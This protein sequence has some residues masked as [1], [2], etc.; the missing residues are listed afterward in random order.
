MVD[1]N[2]GDGRENLAEVPFPAAARDKADR[3]LD[4]DNSTIP[5]HMDDPPRSHF[6]RRLGTGCVACF[7]A[8]HAAFLLAQIFPHPLRPYLAPAYYALTAC[9]QSWDMFVTIPAYHR[10]DAAID[11]RAADG[12]TRELG[13]MLPGFIS[14][15]VGARPRRLNMMERM[16]ADEGF[17]PYRLS[18]LERA[19]QSLHKEGLLRPGESWSL[20]YDLDQIR[21]LFHIRRDGTIAAREVRIFSPLDD[22]TLAP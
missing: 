19:D 14:F 4:P 11:L 8:I 21:H 15:Q 18:Y 20:R 22:K 10:F 16:M 6:L 9:D 17:L 1:T 12:T 13:P 7:A 5:H 2:A 3:L